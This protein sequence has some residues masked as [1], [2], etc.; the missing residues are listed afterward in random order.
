MSDFPYPTHIE[1]LRTFAKVLGVKAGNKHLDD[2][3]KDKTADYRLIDEFSKEVFDYLSKTFGNEIS[4]ILKQGFHAYLTEYM[5]HVSNIYAD[6]LSRSEIGIALC[7]TLL[8][9]H[10]V[11]TIESALC[12]VSSC[13]GQ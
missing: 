8:S 1:T 3:A 5:T 2:K 7:K 10:V 6:G 4:A 12:L 9:K 11:N 13:S